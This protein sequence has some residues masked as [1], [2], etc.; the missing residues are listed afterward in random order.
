MEVVT[1]IVTTVE[2][3]VA[4]V[5]GLKSRGDLSMMTMMKGWGRMMAR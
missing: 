4:A 1:A 3:K 2:A 5:G